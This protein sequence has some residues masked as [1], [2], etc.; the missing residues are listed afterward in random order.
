M[1][2]TKK[3]IIDSAAEVFIKYGFKKATIE[4]IAKKINKAKG[5]IYYYFKDKEDL[6]RAIIEKEGT[7]LIFTMRQNV[8]KAEMPDEKLK[9]FIITRAKC[10]NELSNYYS[11]LIDKLFIEREKLQKV[12]IAFDKEER[13]LLKEILE[14]GNSS[15][16]FDIKNIDLTL[17]GL[18]FFIK[19]LE[20]SW[21]TEKNILLLEKNLDVVVSLLI[22]GMKK[23]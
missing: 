4:D 22:D 17:D 21:V 20:Y 12:R 14:K 5:Y 18:I 3:D 16:Y 19:G 8:D 15:N 1:E 11:V 6:F 10:L 9:A 7:T 23:R 13:K 2:Q